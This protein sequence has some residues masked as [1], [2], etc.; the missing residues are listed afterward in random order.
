MEG[1]WVLESDRG[2]FALQGVRGIPPPGSCVTLAGSPTS[3]SL[4]FFPISP[5]VIPLAFLGGG[6]N[7]KVSA[8]G[9]GGGGGGVLGLLCRVGSGGRCTASQSQGL[10]AVW[11]SQREQRT[12]LTTPREVSGV[13]GLILPISPCFS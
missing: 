5:E 11:G 7:P 3:L 1:A 4:A 2:G 8:L 13:G 10:S 12:G 9:R 6:E